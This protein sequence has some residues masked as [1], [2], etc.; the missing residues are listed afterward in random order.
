M[1]GWSVG[2][3]IRGLIGG[4]ACLLGLLLTLIKLYKK[5]KSKML[6]KH[7]SVSSNQG[8]LGKNSLDGICLAAHLLLS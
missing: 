6:L 8:E 4:G 3:Y 7:K 1:L 5:L 2:K